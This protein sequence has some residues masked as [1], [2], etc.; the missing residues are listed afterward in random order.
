MTTLEDHDER[1]EGNAFQ[2]VPRDATPTASSYP[3]EADPA[4]DDDTAPAEVPGEQV[5]P[6]RRVEQFPEDERNPGAS[7]AAPG[8]V[9]PPD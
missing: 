3:P 7:P 8:S 6:D 4:P 5:D 1:H 9:E 2:P